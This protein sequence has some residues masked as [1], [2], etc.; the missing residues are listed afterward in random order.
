M[1]Y[2]STCL[3]AVL[4]YTDKMSIKFILSNTKLEIQ[5]F[6]L[7]P[8]CVDQWI[9]SHLLAKPLDMLQKYENKL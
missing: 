5:N 6:V 1:K 4:E 3:W 7:V 2:L 8:K 9:I